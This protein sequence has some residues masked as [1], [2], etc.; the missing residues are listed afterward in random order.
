MEKHLKLCKPI[1]WQN[2]VSFV[3]KS[4]I[5]HKGEPFMKLGAKE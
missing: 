1:S 2:L 3:G 5:P 4:F